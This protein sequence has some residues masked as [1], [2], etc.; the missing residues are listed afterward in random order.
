MK[1]AM[2]L[3]AIQELPVKYLW[4]HDAF[5]VG[6]DGPT[7]QPIEQEA[8]LRLLEKIKNHSGN[9]SFL[10]LRPADS[11]E[12]AVAWKMAIENT[13]TPTGLVLSRQGITDLPSVSKS[14]YQEALEAQKGGY[15]VKDVENADVILI[16]NG[17]EVST[18]FEGAKLLED[19]L[20]LKV[21]IVSVPSEG[22]FRQQT[23]EYQH[24]V[25]S[26][27]IKAF[28]LT[29]GLPVNLNELVGKNGKVFGLDHFGYSAPSKV[30]DEKF[31]FTGQN[32][33]KQVKEFLNK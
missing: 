1:P 15:V 11:A 19:N 14:R 33:F 22:V 18:L 5:R 20:K 27:E 32:V 7:H 3:S 13:S 16:A 28:G 8:Q 26:P 25:I 30:L 23:E 2:R 21:K 24:K 12:T 17:S 6:E 4:T 10:A 29:A 9:T 31:G